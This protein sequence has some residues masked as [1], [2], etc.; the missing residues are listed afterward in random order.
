M[1]RVNLLP[2]IKKEYL[3]AE[4]QKTRIV[5]LAFLIMAGA[6]GLVVAFAFFVYA[7]QGF[8]WKNIV[9]GQIKD[10]TQVLSKMEDLNRDLTIQNQLSA[11][12][13]L[14]ES[15]SAYSRLFDM[16]PVLN[17]A[18]PN[19]IT[20]NTVQL[21]DDAKMMMF[22]GRTSTFEALTAFRDTLRYA[23]ASYVQEGQSTP[24]TSPLFKEVVIDA[25][26]L[27]EDQGR[28]YVAFT[29][30]T[31]YNPE[32]F[33]VSSSD[34]KVIIPTLQTSGQADTNRQLFQE[35]Q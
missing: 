15:K 24:T 27:S 21:N 9:N 4:R 26:G 8:A 1:I 35:A 31:T 17:P 14:H 18:P 30:R 28:Q 23:E 11:L 6:V 2:D 10:K 25:S 22:V 19:S 16:L 20:L 7:I 32:A 5:I 29:I 3:R 33:N 12:P 34:I 13:A